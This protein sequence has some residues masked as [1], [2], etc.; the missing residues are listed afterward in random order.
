[1]IR[2]DRPQ[3][4]LRPRIIGPASTSGL[5]LLRQAF[6]PYHGAAHARVCYSAAT[7]FT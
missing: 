3:A 1:V 4:L 7:T 5:D 6:P 2:G